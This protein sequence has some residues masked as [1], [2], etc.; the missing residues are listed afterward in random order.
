MAKYSFPKNV[1][2]VFEF[3]RSDSFLKSQY[4]G[5]IPESHRIHD[6]TLA[7]KS[8]TDQDVQRP[9][10]FLDDIT[11]D[12]SA[13]IP[14]LDD[15][16]PMRAM[17]KQLDTINYYDFIHNQITLISKDIGIN[18]NITKVLANSIYENLVLCIESRLMSSD[19]HPYFE[20]LYQVYKDNA[21]PCG[22]KG[23]HS[24]QKGEFIIYTRV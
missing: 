12:A 22:W 2:E 23:S 15:E 8:Y 3:M 6:A 11:S 18:K 24:W 13:E 10:Y 21:F 17:M 1:Q 14:S 9:L 20:R 5:S 19:S 7:I 4:L 16:K